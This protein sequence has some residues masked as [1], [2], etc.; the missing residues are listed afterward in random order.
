VPKV[1]VVDESSAS[2]DRVLRAARDFSARR[3]ELWRDVHIEHLEVHDSG[4]AWADVTEGNPWPV[5]VVWERLHYDWSEPG[6]IKGHV[7]DS[8]IFKP[9][10]TWEIH[11]TALDGGGSRVEILAV[12]HLRGV[13]GWMLAPLFP[14]GLARRDVADYLRRFLAKVEAA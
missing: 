3:A 6:A 7:I 11:A 13:K 14:L 1:H 10:S 8:N 5:G 2:A 12:R 4:E 9:G